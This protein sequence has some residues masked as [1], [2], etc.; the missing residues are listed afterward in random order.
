MKPVYKAR[1]HDTNV[2]HIDS[3]D[4]EQVLYSHLMLGDS[5]LENFLNEYAGLSYYKKLREMVPIF[6]AGVGGDKIENLWYRLV[7]GLLIK[8]HYLS[9]VEHVYL[10]IGTNNLG[11][12]DKCVTTI[13]NGIQ[14]I[15]GLLAKELPELKNI[16]IMNIS[17]RSDIK[18]NI[19]NTVN[20]LLK[21]YVENAPK[22]DNINIHYLEWSSELTNVD[23][24]IKPKYYYDHVHLNTAGYEIM[25]NHI[26]ETIN[27]HIT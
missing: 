11:K 7:N 2:K 16:Y 20:V 6:N 26:L 23:G 9:N 14:E 22:H 18:P 8:N 12:T 25:Y 15:V 13:L 3:L 1:S 19:V 4:K 24:T 21:N 17:Q 27:K 5:M 10:L